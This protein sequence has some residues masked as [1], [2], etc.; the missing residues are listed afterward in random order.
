M[1][2]ELKR[3]VEAVAKALNQKQASIMRDAI[4]KGLPLVKSGGK[5]VHLRAELAGFVASN[6]ERFK[7]TEESII[8]EAV[9]RGIESV[10]L[11]ATIAE[12]KKEGTMSPAMAE[13]MLKQSSL[14]AYPEQRA[15]R[16]AMQERG[17]LAIQL[18]DLLRHCPEA[19]ERKELIEKHA[20]LTHK[21]YAGGPVMWGSGVTTEH[22]KQNI[23]SFESEIAK[24]AVAPPEAVAW[25]AKIERLQQAPPHYSHKFINRLSVTEIPAAPSPAKPSKP[26]KKKSGK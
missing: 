25:T 24:G 19:R 18:D 5:A 12:A 13:H 11:H 14:T 15:V 7:R 22:L 6:A 23:A 10:A 3:E 17:K 21:L 20:E 1:D 16:E 26:G 2:A 9:E 4:R 8:S